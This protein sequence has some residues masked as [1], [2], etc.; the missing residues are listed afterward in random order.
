MSVRSR[1]GEG[2]GHSRV[3]PVAL[4]GTP[5]SGKSSVAALLRPRFSVVEVAE[6]AVRAGLGRR[7]GGSIIVDLP[8][9]Q[10][11]FPGLHRAHPHQVYVGHLAHL[12]PIRDIVVLRCNPVVLAQ[13]LRRLRR[14]SARDR[15]AN[16]VSEAIDL[17]LREAL[18]PGRRVWEVDTTGR[19][20][21]EVAREVRLRIRK[22]GPS[23]YGRVRWL[24][25]PRVTDY[26]L[27]TAP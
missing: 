24:T 23:V 5:G 19:S 17:V 10:H 11:R 6:L 21:E 2:I 12:L 20:P 3:A 9:L 15:D 25:D 1:E 13:R 14:G 27:D 18:G 22:R 4:T 7:Q 16:V 26:L 8:Q